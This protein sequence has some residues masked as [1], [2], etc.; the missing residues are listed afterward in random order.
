MFC[1][2]S[3]LTD[4]KKQNWTYIFNILNPDGNSV[5][6][7]KMEFISGDFSLD[8]FISLQQ[9]I[10]ALLNKYFNNAFNNAILCFQILIINALRKVHEMDDW[11]NGLFGCLIIETLFNSYFTEKPELKQLNSESFLEF[12]TFLI[13][14]ITTMRK[15]SWRNIKLLFEKYYYYSIQK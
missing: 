14:K 13:K 15:K 8:Q 9:P 1:D 6:G 3:C 7:C 11:E 2:L 10:P 12:K 5:F 4:S